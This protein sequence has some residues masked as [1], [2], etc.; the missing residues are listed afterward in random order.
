M[1]MTAFELG[2][3]KLAYMLPTSGL[4]RGAAEILPGHATQIMQA[5]GK[6]WG[7]LRGLLSRPAA[8]SVVR[9]PATKAIKT[10]AEP[11]TSAIATADPSMLERAIDA[12][13]EQVGRVLA[14]PYGAGAAIGGIGGGYYGIT[15]DR[16]EP[17]LGSATYGTL[18]AFGGSILGALASRAFRR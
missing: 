8:Q 5:P 14:T 13:A 7:A 18:G 2:R 4:Y 3:S 9:K 11:V 12:G 1:P 6:A 10:V 16:E 15:H 17:M